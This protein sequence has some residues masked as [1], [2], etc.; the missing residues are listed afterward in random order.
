MTAGK[1]QGFTLIEMVMVVV[2]MGVMASIAMKS[3]KVSMDNSRFDATVAEMDKLSRAIVGDERLISNGMRTDFG[4]VGDI[5]A[6]P[7]SLD[8]LMANPGYA[9]WNGPYLQNDF[10]EDI[11]GFKLDAWNNPYSYSG[12]LSII[13]SGAGEAITRNLAG[14]L[15]ELTSNTVIGVVRDKS[16][17]PPGDSA[18]QV[19]V[20][21]VYPDGTGAYSSLSTAPGASG[22]FSFTGTI[23]IGVHQIRAVAN[24][25]TVT[26]YVPVYPGKSAHTELRFAR[27]KW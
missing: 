25:D 24:A 3:L 23:P 13:S 16:L 9:T 14:S 20:S 4:Y 17:S 21:I 2:I 19:T 15:S 22:E 10:A 12:G 1:T 27:D 6:L 5:G 8:D 11:D 18:L 7:A 26:K